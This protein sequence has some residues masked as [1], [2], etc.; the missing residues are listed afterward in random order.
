MVQG[1]AHLPP[2]SNHRRVFWKLPQI[3]FLCSQAKASGSLQGPAW[4][5]SDRLLLVRGTPLFRPKDLCFYDAIRD[6]SLYTAQ[7][8]TRASVVPL[9]TSLTTRPL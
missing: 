1:T 6:H 9:Y 4:N 5:P 2:G 7:M 8:R 3:Q